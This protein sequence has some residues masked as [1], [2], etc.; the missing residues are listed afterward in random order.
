VIVLHPTSVSLQEHSSMLAAFRWLILVGI[1]AGLLARDQRNPTPEFWMSQ[2]EVYSI[3]LL[4][5]NGGLCIQQTKFYIAN[6]A[7]IDSHAAGKNREPLPHVHFRDDY[8]V[9]EDGNRYWDTKFDA[10]QTAERI[11]DATT[12]T[13]GGTF[14]LRQLSAGGTYEFWIDENQ[15]SF[16]RAIELATM[17]PAGEIKS[18]ADRSDSPSAAASNPALPSQ[19]EALTE[20]QWKTGASGSYKA[21]VNAFE[22]QSIKSIRV[23]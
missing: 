1:A 23:K 6:S 8:V 5:E 16:F 19:P 22:G 2:G 20:I 13:N 17:V 15:N 9:V 11:G 3:P 21:K 7:L 14:T 10:P 4:D 12:R 18:L